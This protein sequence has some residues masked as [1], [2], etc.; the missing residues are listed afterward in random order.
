[1]KHKT[2]RLLAATLALTLVF[3]S[4]VFAESISDETVLDNTTV[5]EVLTEGVDYDIEI[6]S[7]DEY[8]QAVEENGVSV[9]GENEADTKEVTAVAKDNDSDVDVDVDVDIDNDN[10]GEAV[11]YADSVEDDA[12]EDEANLNAYS[13]LSQAV[14]GGY[15]YLDVSSGY[16]SGVDDTVTNLVIP[17]TISGKSVV[18]IKSKAFYGNTSLVSVTIPSSVQT[19]D[20]YAFGLCENLTTVKVQTDSLK[21][22]LSLGRNVFSS[23]SSLKSVDLSDRTTYL[24]PDCFYNCYSLS[25]IVIPNSV[26]GGISNAFEECRS[27]T[28]YASSTNCSRFAN[29]SY[30][31]TVITDT[32]NPPS[33]S[34]KGVM[35]G[36]KVTFESDQS[37]ATIYYSR[38]T[39]KLKTTDSHVDAGGSVT[40]TN[41]Y[42]TLYAKVYYNDRWSVPA[43]LVLKIPTVNAPTITKSSNGK[44][45]IKT[46]TPNA[47]VYY[48]LDGTRPSESNYAGKFWCSRDIKIPNG[49]TVKAIARRSCFTDSSVVTTQVTW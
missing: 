14:S 44:T 48:T 28:I 24:G 4:S 41:G 17:S 5:E 9:Y 42:G 6:V 34:V 15:V 36:R 25:K 32:P 38:T 31:K 49:K 30:I 7:E 47:I 23:C 22:G 21:R 1:M 3:S 11:L 33:F 16:I 27:L 10:D 37:D 8:Q 45:K 18:G 12:T 2:K 40:F 26:T 43:K 13:T 35:G 20:T 39:S 46:T 29:Y 19:I